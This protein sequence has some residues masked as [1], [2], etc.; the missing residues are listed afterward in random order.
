M[1]FLQ[2]VLALNKKVLEAEA[3]RLQ[4]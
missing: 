3:N 1:F 2:K 4:Q